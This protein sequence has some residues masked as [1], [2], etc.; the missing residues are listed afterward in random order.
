MSAEQIE[1]MKTE[2]ADVDIN[3]GKE[4]DSDAEEEVPDPELYLSAQSEP[5]STAE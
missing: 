4:E 2:F 3:N 1:N 5:V